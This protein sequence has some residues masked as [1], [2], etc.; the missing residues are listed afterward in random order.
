MLWITDSKWREV[1]RG[2]WSDSTS[3]SAV[4]PSADYELHVSAGIS[5]GLNELAG[6][7]CCVVERL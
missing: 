6:C 5:A 3:D 4:L 2:N 7:C 1:I